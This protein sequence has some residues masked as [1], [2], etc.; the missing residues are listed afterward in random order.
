MVTTNEILTASIRETYEF[1][2]QVPEIYQI[3]KQRA[4]EVALK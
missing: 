2:R 4:K 3:C 1:F